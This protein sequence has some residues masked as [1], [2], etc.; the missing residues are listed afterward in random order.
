MSVISLERST[1]IGTDMRVRAEDGS[2]LRVSIFCL[3]GLALS[4]AIIPGAETV[5]LAWI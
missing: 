4:L 5:A 2:L 3:I 1:R